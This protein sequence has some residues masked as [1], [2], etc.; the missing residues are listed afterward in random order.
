MEAA[1]ALSTFPFF[2][3]RLP[4]REGASCSRA[5]SSEAAAE[6]F[7]FRLRRRPDSIPER[8]IFPIT[9]VPVSS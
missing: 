2:L 7:R 5:S 6:L 8:S 1:S 9:F 3:P 4:R